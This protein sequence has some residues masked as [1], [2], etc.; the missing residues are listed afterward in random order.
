[1][2]PHLKNAEKE[3]ALNVMTNSK[4]ADQKK[5]QKSHQSGRFIFV[6]FLLSMYISIMRHLLRQYNTPLLNSEKIA[7]IF[8]CIF[9]V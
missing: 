8:I 3:Q 6:V 7:I 2:H 1:M 5:K 4:K 9:F